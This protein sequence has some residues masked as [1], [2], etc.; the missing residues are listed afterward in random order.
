[1]SRECPYCERLSKSDELVFENEFCVY[2]DGPDRAGCIVPKRH[3][4]SLFELGP[5]ELAASFSLLTEV[6]KAIDMKHK[7]EGYTLSWS[8]GEVA[9]QQVAHT[10]LWVIPRF[11]AESFAGKGVEDFILGSQDSG[12]DSAAESNLMEEFENFLD[13]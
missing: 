4:E 13:S 8:C 3:C 6:K 12:M 1:M 2:L 5:A 10:H 11:Q 9:G 7:P